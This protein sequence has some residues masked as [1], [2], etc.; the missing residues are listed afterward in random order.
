MSLIAREFP[1]MHKEGAL[2]KWSY[3]YPSCLLLH[4]NTLY[5]MLMSWL[6]VNTFISRKINQLE[7]MN[8]GQAMVHSKWIEKVRAE[9][10]IV[11]F[12][13]VWRLYT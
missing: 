1:V 7:W 9:G 8:K 13:K 12:Q 3:G 2:Y 6:N 5:G 4:F 10:N 11:Y